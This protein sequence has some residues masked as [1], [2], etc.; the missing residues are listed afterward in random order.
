MKRLGSLDDR[1]GKFVH[2][3]TRAKPSDLASHRAFIATRS[4][5]SVAALA[6]A[7][8]CFAAGAPPAWEAAALAW[9]SLPLVAVAVVSRSGDLRLGEAL[10]LLTWIGLA[11]TVALGAGSPM[12]LA[13]A[14]M[15]PVEAAVAGALPRRAVLGA[16]G[17]TAA[18][19]ALAACRLP[20]ASSSPSWLAMAGLGGV[21]AYGCCVALAAQG[22]AQSRTEAERTARELFGRLAGSLDSVVLRLDRSGAV[23][24]ATASTERLFALAPRDLVGRGLFERLHVADRPAFLKLA[25]EAAASGEPQVATLRLRSGRTVPSPRGDYADPVFCPV[26]LALRP[27]TDPADVGELLGLL[28]D[29]SERV[30]GE[31]AAAEARTAS[32][33]ALAGR[34]LFLANVTHELRTPLNAIIGFAEMLA[35]EALAPA[36]PAKR[37]EYAA[38]VQQSGLHLLSVVN[39]ILDATKIEAGQ[40][41]VFPEPFDLG[42]LVDQCCEMVSLKAEQSGVR[43]GRAVAPGLGDLVGDPRACRQILLNLLSNALKF[44]P[45]GG[46]V[47]VSARPDGNCALLTVADSGIGIAARDLPRLG[48]PFFQARGS[49][50][51]SADGTGLGLSVVRGLVGLHGGTIAIESAPGQ[52]TRVV[53]RLPADGRRPT[54]GTVTKIETIPRYASSARHGEAPVG[55]RMHKLA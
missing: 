15:V 42:R 45:R 33:R 28:R 21:L 29:V 49:Y 14:L 19:M 23:Q 2:P 44:T 30:E 54:S 3:D 24:H 7:P 48:D 26:D 51:R 10:S 43:L 38:I 34:D 46:E 1:I 16:A 40:F 4:G 22:V 9:L 53:V 39:G 12:G 18:A 25:T 50:D 20:V 37:R 27:A 8:L 55:G 5:L 47:T 13:L 6:T 35:S 11:V 17:V 52:G 32:E 36:D 41:D 31:R